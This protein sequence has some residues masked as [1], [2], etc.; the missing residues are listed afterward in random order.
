MIGMG[1]GTSPLFTRDIETE[2]FSATMTEF[3]EV[4]IQDSPA[5]FTV[6]SLHL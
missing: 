5:D 2:I 1:F 6:P 4:R 3:K